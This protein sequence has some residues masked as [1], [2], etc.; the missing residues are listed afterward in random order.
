MQAPMKHCN[1]NSAFLFSNSSLIY[2][3][4]NDL[5]NAYHNNVAE[6]I[7]NF[8]DKNSYILGECVFTVSDYLYVSRHVKMFIAVFDEISHSW[9]RGLILATL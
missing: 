7:L 2:E 9:L 1:K 8:Y 6:E 4:D 5:C 3:S